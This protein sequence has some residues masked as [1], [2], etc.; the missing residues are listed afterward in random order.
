MQVNTC[1][2]VSVASNEG[3]IQEDTYLD[4]AGPD[5]LVRVRCSAGEL[6]GEA[7]AD[8][9]CDR[10]LGIPYAAPPLGG[11]RFQPA[12][13]H[14]GWQAVLDATR[15][16][17]ASAQVFDPHE[18]AF[19]ELDDG[20]VR[21]WAGSEDSLTLNIWR[22]QARPKPCP[23]VIWVH[24]GANW[25]ESSRLAI[26]DGAV[27][28]AGGVVFIS[29]NYRLGLFGFLDLSPIGGPGQAHSN[30][31]TDQLAAIEWVC[32]NIAGFGGDPANITL[33]GESA[34]AM[35]ISWLLASGRLP[36][37]V[38]RLMLMSGVASVIGLGRD[39]VQSAHDPAE[40][41][42]RAGEFLEALGFSTFQQLCA[43]STAE[44]LERHTTVVSTSSILLEMDTLF[45]PRTGAVS[46][47]D[48]F[49]AA[50]AGVGSDRE[51]LIGYTGYELGLWLLWDDEL[52]RR[53]PEWA[54]RAIPWIPDHVRADLSDRYR[55]WLPGEQAAR[56]G[57]HMLGD[58]MFAM[59]SMWMADLLATS[60]APVHFYRFDWEAG[61]RVGALHAADQAFL[62]GHANTA[63]GE[64]LVGKAADAAGASRRQ[65]IAED[66]L[67]AVL[68]FAAGGSANFAAG[69]GANFAAGGSA[70]FAGAAWPAWTAAGRAVRL[71]GGAQPVA[72]DPIR[73]RRQWWTDNVL[74]VSLGGGA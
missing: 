57:M 65:H 28:A 45:Y 69:G 56:L 59:P 37:G 46:A 62:F 23:V 4:A 52:D 17:A 8:R 49:E 27:F 16:G 74:P 64:P 19:A 60:G 6:V 15:F 18:A 63:V 7:L 14:D 43:A 1:V 24:G 25:L 51:F 41:R 21:C 34:G 55:A 35:D 40:G 2:L 26:Y 66:M 48:P 29:F 31:L 61:P 3:V 9:S 72:V 12:R 70:D 50:R 22:P 73:P 38:R 71:F 20:P 33:V 44:I 11:Q 53:P 36:A 68:A 5:A 54:A 47:L 42:R 32:A 30:G 10:F 67:A 13:P 39:G 58:A